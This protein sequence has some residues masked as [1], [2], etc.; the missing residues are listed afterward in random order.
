MCR[1]L[2]WTS[3][4]PSR[5]GG[6]F[7]TG[8][9]RRTTVTRCGS[10]RLAYARVPVARVPTPA[11]NRRRVISRA[12]HPLRWFTGRTV[13][14][15]RGGVE[16][17]PSRGRRGNQGKWRTQGRGVLGLVHPLLVEE[18]REDRQD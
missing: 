7:G 17:D 18:V 3:R 5:S 1:S 16:G 4:L 10:I 15:R 2:S 14:C 9:S 12:T 13:P 8:K 11:R 6:R